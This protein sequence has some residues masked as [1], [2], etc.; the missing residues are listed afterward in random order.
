SGRG[1]VRGQFFTRD[2]VLVASTMQEGVIR[3]RGS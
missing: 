3:R 1:L 2:G